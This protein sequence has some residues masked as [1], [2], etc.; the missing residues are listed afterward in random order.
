MADNP[1]MDHPPA[2]LANDIGRLDE[3]TLSVL[4]NLL[5]K[6]LTC[7]LVDGRLQPEREE[8]SWR[9]GAR[10]LLLSAR[11][12]RGEAGEPFPIYLRPEAVAPDDYELQRLR[13]DLDPPSVLRDDPERSPRTDPRPGCTVETGLS[14]R[15]VITR[16]EIFSEIVPVFSSDCWEQLGERAIDTRI[17]FIGSVRGLRHSVSPERVFA[18]HADG[19]DTF[20]VSVE[21]SVR[22]VGTGPGPASQPRLTLV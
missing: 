16:I 19:R 11:P 3:D 20:H 21:T 12:G 9:I 4:R 22:P 18:V 7:Q 13:A 1:S 17:E 14:T 6:W 10:G 8:P 5:G 2:D 15:F